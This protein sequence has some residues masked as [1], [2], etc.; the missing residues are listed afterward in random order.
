MSKAVDLVARHLAA[1]WKYDW[2]ELKET[3]SSKAEL[4]V[5]HDAWTN[6]EWEIARLYRHISQAWD[7]SPSETHLFDRGDG[8]VQ[9]KMRL[10]NGGDWAKDIEG[11]YRVRGDRIDRIQIVDGSAFSLAD[12]PPQPDHPQS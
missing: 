5:S 1:V 8:I 12:V 2:V 4:R 11:D 3:L 10:T 6:S 9:V 7:F